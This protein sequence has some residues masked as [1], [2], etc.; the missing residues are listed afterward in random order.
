[1]KPIIKGLDTPYSIEVSEI[2]RLYANGIISIECPNCHHV[3]ELDLEEQYIEYGEVAIQD[4]CEE[5]EYEYGVS[6]LIVE[7]SIIIKLK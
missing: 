2:K 4:Y 6:D 5:C 3:D 7:A 1:M